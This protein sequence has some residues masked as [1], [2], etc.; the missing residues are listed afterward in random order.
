[1]QRFATESVVVELRE[2]SWSD[3]FKMESKFVKLFL[4]VFV[5]KL[6]VV[7]SQSQTTVSF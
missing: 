1:M 2:E 3:C 4:Y 6:T 5:I 7:D